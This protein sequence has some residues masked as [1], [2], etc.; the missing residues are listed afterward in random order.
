MGAVWGDYDND[1]FEDLF[2]CKC[3]KSELFKNIAGKGFE[4][5]TVKCNMPDWANAN[6]AIILDAA[7]WPA[8]ECK[9]QKVR[10]FPAESFTGKLLH[11]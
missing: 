2:N 6:T 3:G 1:G 8:M 9:S 5:V 4:R 10:I 7:N 11:Q